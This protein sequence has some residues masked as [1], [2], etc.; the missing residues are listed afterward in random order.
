MWWCTYGWIV[1]WRLKV[2]CQS[3]CRRLRRIFPLRVSNSSN[4]SSRISAFLISTIRHTALNNHIAQNVL[5]S[6]IFIIIV[7]SYACFYTFISSFLLLLRVYNFWFCWKFYFYFI[8]LR[9]KVDWCMHRCTNTDRE[10]QRTCR[11][12]CFAPFSFYF[13]SSLCLSS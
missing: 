12:F 11:F 1:D 9:H 4:T 7:I 10:R 2:T 5:D 8:F 6:V 3:R 13:V